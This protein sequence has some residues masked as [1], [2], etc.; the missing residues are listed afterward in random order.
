M[1][2]FEEIWD[3]SKN[4][5]GWFDKSEGKLLYKLIVANKPKRMVE[6]GSFAGRS[7]VIFSVLARELK[8]DFTT[9]DNFSSGNTLKE[10]TNNLDK[11]QGNYEIKYMTSDQAFDDIKKPVNL[12]FIDT[13]HT[14]QAVKHDLNLWLPKV[15]KKG[16]VLFHDYSTKYSG[17]VQ[18]VDERK[19]LYKLKL[20]YSLMATLKTI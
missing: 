13:V 5:R 9:V 8:L 1:K 14:Y 10:L 20:A 17:V 4:I 3:I 19:E 2:T 7:S 16:L 15:P 6:L 11:A 12:L 18:A